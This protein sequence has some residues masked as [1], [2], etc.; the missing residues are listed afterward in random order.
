MILGGS[1]EP[2]RMAISDL[3]RHCDIPAWAADCV[4]H[5]RFPTPK[6]LKLAFHLVPLE[7]GGLP[8]LLQ[9]RLHAPRVLRVSKVAEYL[10]RRMRELGLAVRQAALF[11][12]AGQQEVWDA[13]AGHAPGDPE[14]GR[15]LPLFLS[16][17][18]MAV[19]WDFTLAAVRQWIWKNPEDLV[20]NYSI[21][22][23]ETMLRMPSI[24]PPE[25]V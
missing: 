21:S 5:G 25:E 7:Q 3:D 20:I 18:G 14:E 1:E 11:F 23:P 8:S 22:G 6:S 10:V 19:P 17:N 24:K 9:S 12:D 4:L 15:G 2:W 13:A 16:C